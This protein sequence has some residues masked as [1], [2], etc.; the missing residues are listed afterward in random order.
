MDSTWVHSLEQG[1]TPAGIAQG[2]DRWGY[3]RSR[4]SG[5]LG[6]LTAAGL[7]DVVLGHT[8]RQSSEGAFGESGPRRPTYY[9][10]GF[11]AAATYMGGQR[12]DNFAAD[13][14]QLAL[15]DVSVHRWGISARVN[16]APEGA[17][18]PAYVPVRIDYAMNDPIA[19]QM[20]ADETGKDA[21]AQIEIEGLDADYK[22]YCLARMPGGEGDTYFLAVE[23]KSMFLGREMPPRNKLPF[24]LYM[25]TPNSM[26]RVPAEVDDAQFGSTGSLAYT[27][28]DSEGRTCFLSTPD[29]SGKPAHLRVNKQHQLGLETL[30][31]QLRHIRGSP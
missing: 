28:Q 2:C 22:P 11:K 29:M 26:E 1:L 18:S 4:L 31:R 7:E 25:G 17:S 21:L 12:L 19:L 20:Q 10:S 27:F 15:A 8:Y 5:V 9:P 24:A 13:N 6:G 3:D 23:L 14:P 30:S 16:A